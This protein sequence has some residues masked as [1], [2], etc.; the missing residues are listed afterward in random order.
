M[1]VTHSVSD[2]GLLQSWSNNWD[3]SDKHKLFISFH[4]SAAAANVDNAGEIELSEWCIS[5]ISTE[6]FFIS[7]FVFLA[8]ALISSLRISQ[9]SLTMMLMVVTGGV[10]DNRDD[11]IDNN[12]AIHDNDAVD[13][14]NE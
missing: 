13:G 8:F 9:S 7:W 1:A 4:F 14:D 5:F 6:V 2:Q 3:N 11:V 12:T 10:I